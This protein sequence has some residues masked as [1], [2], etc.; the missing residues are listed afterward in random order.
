MATKLDKPAEEISDSD[1]EALLIEHQK[2]IHS[3]ANTYSFD[4][5]VI[6][7][8]IA[9]RKQELLKTCWGQL[10]Q[11]QVGVTKLAGEAG[12]YGALALLR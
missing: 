8:G 4:Q 2:T 10:S 6:G 7:G 1:W 11:P 9:V 3:L 5:F 12:L